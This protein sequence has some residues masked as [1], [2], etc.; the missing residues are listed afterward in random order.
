LRQ[1]VRASPRSSVPRTAFGLRKQYQS[2]ALPQA[3]AIGIYGA[4]AD[5]LSDPDED[6]D[7]DGQSHNDAE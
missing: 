3:D 6:L 4:G 1:T 7:A 2:V 5:D